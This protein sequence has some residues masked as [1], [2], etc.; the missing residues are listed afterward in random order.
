MK[1][2]TCKSC[3]RF[4][5]YYCV[6]CNDGPYCGDCIK[7]VEKET[8]EGERYYHWSCEKCFEIFASTVEALDR[9]RSEFEEKEEV[10]LTKLRQL[11]KEKRN[12]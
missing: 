8:Y 12:G 6:F 1:S 3:G 5:S 7:G 9:L 2:F 4:A 10:L 11:A